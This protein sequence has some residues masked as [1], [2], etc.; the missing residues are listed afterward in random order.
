[1]DPFALI[2]MN[3]RVYDP[4]LGAF[5]SSDPYVQAPDHPIN[6]NR[7][8][9]CLNNPLIYTDPSG[10]FIFTALASIIPGAQ[11]LLPIAIGA[12]IGAITGGFRGAQDPNIGFWGG[13]VR[14]AAVGAVGGALSMVGGGTFVANVAWG[15]GE[16]AVTGG[17]DAALWGNDI[18]KGMLNGAVIGGAFAAATSG[19]EAYGNYKDG[20]GFRT[21]KGVM[22]NLLEKEKYSKLIFYMEE[23]YG[24]SKTTD[25]REIYSG[26]ESHEMCFCS[27][28]EYYEYA[29]YNPPSTTDLIFRDEAFLSL[30]HMKSSYIHEFGHI[31]LDA[32]G[33]KPYLDGHPYLKL[34]GANGYAME[35]FNAGNMHI[36]TSYL[37]R[38]NYM[39]NE[40]G[41]K[42]WFYAIPQ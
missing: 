6:F 31:N 5:I 9:Y 12:D 23:K 27:E 18:G 33:V 35:I 34:D 26:Y 1:M 41:F 17:L 19:I 40:F 37:R 22:K 29:A 30:D 20:Y 3:G 8:V 13:A 21:D 10:E 28:K 2:N 14:G 4:E 42:K 38:T 39:W 25:G 15:I 32:V 16:G 11:V 36:S 24:L 7:Y